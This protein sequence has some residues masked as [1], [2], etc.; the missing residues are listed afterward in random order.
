MIR[1]GALAVAPAL[2]MLAAA[3]LGSLALFGLAL[4]LIVLYVGIAVSLSLAARRVTL[5]RTIERG[6]VQEGLPVTVRFEVGGLRAL[7]VRVEVLG[8]GGRWHPLEGGV[9]SFELVIDRPGAHVL[10]PSPL[11]LRDDLGLFSRLTVSGRPD[12]LLVLPEPAPPPARLRAGGALVAA[13]PEPDGLRPYTPG[14]P[15]SRVHWASAARGGELQERHFTSARDRLPLVVVD[16]LGA[17]GAALDWIARSAAGI[18][19]ALARSSGCRVLLPGDRVP[20]TLDDSGGWPAMHRRLAALEPGT[21]ATPTALGDR[22]VL[23]VR[24]ANAPTPLDDR[25]DLP[26]GVIALADWERRH[27]PERAAA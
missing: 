2:L 7:P 11:L 9:G 24:A 17:D 6:D 16:T 12:S 13:D 23:H 18:V 19:L 15:M 22:D 3:T 26:P 20:T 25:G 4:A 8:P 21:A 5:V 10:G 14:T 27:G 1:S